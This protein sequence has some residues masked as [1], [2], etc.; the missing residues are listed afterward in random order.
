[1]RNEAKFQSVHGV[2]IQYNGTFKE[3][4]NVDK[5]ALRVCI[6]CKHI[7]FIRICVCACA[8]VRV[9]DTVYNKY[10]AF[11]IFLQ[12]WITMENKIL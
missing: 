4:L 11:Q 2:T 5:H 1:M 8:C 6:M 12:N 7:A 9:C 10:K 3:A